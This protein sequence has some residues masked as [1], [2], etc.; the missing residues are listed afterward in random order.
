M[1]R[2]PV[3]IV[4]KGRWENPLTAKFFIEDGVDFK[5]AVEPQE[6]DNYCQALGSKYVLKLP[7]SNLGLGSYPARNYCWEDSIKNG[8]DR[9]WLFDDNIRHVKRLHKGKRIRCNSKIALQSIEDFTDRYENLYI[10]GMDYQYFVVNHYHKPFTQNV[11]AYSAMLIKSNMPYRWRLKYNEDVDLCLQVLN[12]G[13]CTA[14]FK[15]FNVDKVSTTAGMKGGNQTELYNNNDNQKFWIKTKML[16]DLWPE[17]VEIKYKFKR[18]HHHV[19]WR[20]HFKQNLIRRADIDWDSISKK[21]YDIKL[22]QVA[23]I[24]SKTLSKF[25]EDAKKL[26]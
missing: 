5:I 13:Y 22:K 16:A 9:H 19:N 7:F 11:H 4:S 10:S 23:P 2:Y 12:D 24:K 25:Y 20:K 17:Y 21:K 8:F 14:L 6:Y 18:P 26:T 15:A 1:N 3:Y